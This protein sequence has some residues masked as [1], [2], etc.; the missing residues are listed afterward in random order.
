MSCPFSSSILKLKKKI[1]LL[2][3]GKIADGLGRS[4]GAKQLDQ[5]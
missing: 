2:A 5:F 4:K 3:I 1:H